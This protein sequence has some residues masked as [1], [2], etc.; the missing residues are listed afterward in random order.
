MSD[1]PFEMNGNGA[2]AEEKLPGLSAEELAATEPKPDLAGAIQRAENLLDA[3]VKQ[4]MG[5]TIRGLLV[6]SPGVP[7]DA[8]LR[9][10]ARTTAQLMGDAITGDLVPVMKVRETIR[11]AFAQSLKK[12]P[13]RTPMQQGPSSPVPNA[14]R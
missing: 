2:Q 11:D 13:I 7:P 6:S 1:Q 8:L 10:V 9:S 14:R 3:Q 12:A 5:V 4:I